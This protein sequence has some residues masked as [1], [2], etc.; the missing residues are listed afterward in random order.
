[1][2]PSLELGC[3]LRF[4][5]DGLPGTCPEPVANTRTENEGQEYSHRE[6]GGNRYGELRA[7]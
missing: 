7:C 1:M 6:D 2:R 5:V 3:A 4:R